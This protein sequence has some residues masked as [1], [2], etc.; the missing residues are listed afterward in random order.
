[1][2]SLRARLHAFLGEAFVETLGPPPRRAAGGG[3]ARHP[4]LD[5]ELK[6]VGVVLVDRSSPRHR[7]T[8]MRHR[9]T[10]LAAVA[11]ACELAARGALVAL[12]LDARA[13][14]AH[15]GTCA[16]VE[17]VVDRHGVMGAGRKKSCRVFPAVDTQDLVETLRGEVAWVRGQLHIVVFMDHHLSTE[18]D[19]AA[20][21]REDFALV[22]GL[23]NAGDAGNAG[24]GGTPLLALS[25]ACSR[26]V[27]AA[28]PTDASTAERARL[29]LHR[30]LA[31][32]FPDVT[33]V[34]VHAG[35]TPNALTRFLENNCCAKRIDPSVDAVLCMCLGDTPSLRY[36]N[37]WHYV[38][39]MVQEPQEGDGEEVMKKKA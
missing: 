1:M 11:V 34:V 12:V 17:H 36:C 15:Y 31:A 30:R 6:G 29:G 23:G 37:R 32:T 9:V 27:I 33:S 28:G 14:A 24:N 26:I 39:G 22:S 5:S 10:P 20:A 13:V 7:T 3:G 38:L 4:Y 2:D 19:I 8:P 18:T 16:D 21:A 25:A 35:R